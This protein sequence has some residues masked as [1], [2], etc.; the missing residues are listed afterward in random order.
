MYDLGG[1]WYIT[2]EFD[3]IEANIITKEMLTKKIL[4]KYEKKLAYCNLDE[5]SLI[6]KFYDVEGNIYFKDGKY[7][8]FDLRIK[9]FSKKYHNTVF[10]TER[11]L[12]CLRFKTMLC[13][14]TTGAQEK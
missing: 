12:S 8:Q 10:K 6:G 9:E 13:G 4:N 1:S 7:Y 5:E 2:G 14:C 11:Q 3:N